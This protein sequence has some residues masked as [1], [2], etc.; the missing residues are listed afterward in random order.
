MVDKDIASRAS[1]SLDEP[2]G[3]TCW[4]H[5]R[6]GIQICMDA[7]SVRQLSADSLRHLKAEQPSEIGGILWGNIRSTGHNSLA[8]ELIPQVISSQA[9]LFNTE[10]ADARNLVSA[11]T[12]PPRNGLRVVGYFRSHIRERLCLSRQDEILIQHHLR[13]PD[14]IFL[15]IRPFQAGICMAG[16][17]FWENGRLQ[18]DVSDLE[19]PFGLPSDNES[20]TLHSDH[21]QISSFRNLA[22][23]LETNYRAER[24][25]TLG[26]ESPGV[27]APGTKSN[28]FQTPEPSHLQ[29]PLNRLQEVAQSRDSQS[30]PTKDPSGSNRRIPSLSWK[31]ALALG[32]TVIACLALYFAFVKYK[33]YTS[34]SASGLAKTKV[35]LQVKVAPAGQIDISW[36]QSSAEMR[37][38]QGATLTIIDGG[39]HRELNIDKDQL[40]SSKLT[41]YP[42]SD[43]VQL[44]LAVHLDATR[45]ISES[46][47]VLA[48]DTNSSRT[49]ADTLLGPSTSLTGPEPIGPIRQRSS[50][51]RIQTSAIP[52]PPPSRAAI[53]T[54]PESPTAKTNFAQLPLHPDRPPASRPVRPK[55][56]PP[57]PLKLSDSSNSSLPEIGATFA[58]FPFPPKPEFRVADSTPKPVVAPPAI[59]A[60]V[61]AR[62]LKQVKP[63][64]DLFSYSNSFRPTTI[65]VQVRINERGHVVG[66]HLIGNDSGND[67]ILAASSIAAAKQWIFTP[68]TLHGKPVSSDHTILFRFRASE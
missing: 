24:N 16:F 3:Y 4:N 36:D 32:L 33:S 64:K 54:S 7:Q 62:P 39:E 28:L 14:A 56:Y 30:V 68:A 25:S 38:A 1:A 46:V 23:N 22:G 31:S 29:T 66:A 9:Q 35:G 21:G 8:I 53:R 67:A 48:P 41:Y 52:A 10:E 34:V 61:S 45:S 60:Y 17:F 26:R 6:R 63:N 43:D 65:T 51:R 49:V 59:P 5:P 15:I 57:A 40:C 42:N 37:K 55:A 47:R 12:G 20:A 50:S 13:D 18:T 58:A 27:D 19:I 2:Y 11:L 44:S